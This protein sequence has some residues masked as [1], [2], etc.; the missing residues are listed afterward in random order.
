MRPRLTALA[1]AA[2]LGLSFAAPARAAELDKY[3]PDTAGFYVQVN[4]KQLLSAQVVRKAIPAAFD[5]YGDLLVPLL[6]LMKQF[7]PN[8]PDI[9]EEEFKKALAELKKPETIAKGFD[10]AKD[11]V[12]DVIVAGDPAD[13]KNVL[14]L[15]KCPPV[16]TPE[17][18]EAMSQLLAGNPQV[19]L[20]RHKTGKSIV[21]ELQTPPPQD[22]T[23]YGAVPEP[24][25]LCFGTSKETVENALSGKG[26]SG[27]NDGLKKLVAERKPADFLFVALSGGAKEDGVKSGYGCL[28][29]DKD[30][31][32]NLSVTFNTPKKAKE[33]AA[34]MNES[35]TNFADTL[36][37][38]LGDKAKEVGP[39]LEKMKAKA[40]GATVT[41]QFA[42]PGQVIE[43]LLAKED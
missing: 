22:Q 5:K 10:A 21:Y 11:I 4:V 26:T 31:S 9:P 24:G 6:P 7:N 12:T 27:L 23:F 13:E 43:K 36:K 20:K 42:V 35:L 14:I 41:G 18:V 17:A 33:A 38:I 15:V 19:K 25:V 28:V 39:L 16:V 3:L 37:G 2:A 34:E 30:I 1:A 40:D 29:L 32:G 8:A